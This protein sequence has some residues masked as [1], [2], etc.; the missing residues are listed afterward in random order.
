LFVGK[1]DRRHRL[2]G[3][4]DLGARSHATRLNHRLVIHKHRGDSKV[5]VPTA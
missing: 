3:A 4:A 5:V 1:T 2:G